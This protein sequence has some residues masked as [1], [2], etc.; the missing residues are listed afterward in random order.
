MVTNTVQ[1]SMAVPLPYL[2]ITSKAI[3][4][5]KVSLSNIENL[6]TVC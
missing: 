5:E 3:E 6:K 2:L 1:I 4:F